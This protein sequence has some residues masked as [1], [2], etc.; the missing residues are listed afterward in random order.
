MTN[1][2]P[3]WGK[4]VVKTLH[5]GFGKEVEPHVLEQGIDRFVY[6]ASQGGYSVAY[7]VPGRVILARTH[8]ATGPG[9]GAAVGFL[10]FGLL[11]AAVG[12]VASSSPARFER[13]EIWADS[14]GSIYVRNL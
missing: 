5:P 10:V 4:G 3:Q 14:H 13:V 2:Q 7:R 12:A 8:A 6:E 11:G 9:T 1:K